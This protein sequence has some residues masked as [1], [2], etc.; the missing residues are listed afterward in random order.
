MDALTVAQLH[1]PKVPPNSRQEHHAA[2]LALIDKVHPIVESRLAGMVRWD[3]YLSGSNPKIVQV[4]LPKGHPVVLDVVRQLYPE[5]GRHAKYYKGYNDAWLDRKLPDYLSQYSFPVPDHDLPFFKPN[6][7][8]KI[9]I[10]LE[11]EE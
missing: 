1:M 9:S 2:V 8:M 6:E 5:E 11:L 10:E 7:N 3:M 4:K